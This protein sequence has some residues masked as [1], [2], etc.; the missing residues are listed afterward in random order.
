MKMKKLPHGTVFAVPLP[1]ETYICGRV[2]LDIYGCLRRRLFPHDSP[3]PAYGK[4]YLVEMYSTVLERPEHVPS[5]VL[6]EGA[7]VE[8][9]EVGNAWPIVGEEPV[10]PR[11]VEFPESLIGFRH[12]L[13]DVAFD[14]GEIRIP[15]PVTREVLARANAEGSRHS[16][17]LWAHTCL[18][19]MGRASEVPSEYKAATLGGTDLRISPHR[20]EIYKHLPF[21]MEQSYFEKQAMLGLNF[22]RLYE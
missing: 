17:F 3:L 5:P 22:E 19:T 2:L 20:A 15:L 12:E 9:K 18:Q 13:G 6:I 16:S 14:C 11:K 7:F 10:D 1:D 4:A 21:R 8:S